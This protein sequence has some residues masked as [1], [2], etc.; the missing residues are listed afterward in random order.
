MFTSTNPANT[1]TR[2]SSHP[3]SPLYFNAATLR[4][5][6]WLTG[7]KIG[8]LKG[9]LISV[10]SGFIH[11]TWLLLLSISGTEQGIIC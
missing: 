4:L 9:K 6:R 8:V 2:S 1:Y 3:E 5:S 7:C 11:N 10:I